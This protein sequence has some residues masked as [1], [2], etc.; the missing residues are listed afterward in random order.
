MA[1]TIGS[2]FDAVRVQLDHPIIDSDGHQVEIGLLS[3][4]NFR[5]LVFTNAVTFWTSTNPDFFH[6]TSVEAAA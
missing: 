6:S 2:K 3:P 5:D 4:A 1:L